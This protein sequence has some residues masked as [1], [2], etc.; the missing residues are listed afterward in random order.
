[1]KSGHL[2]TIKLFLRQRRLHKVF[3]GDQPEMDLLKTVP[4]R[5]IFGKTWQPELKVGGCLKPSP[6]GMLYWNKANGSFFRT[7]FLLYSMQWSR[8]FFHNNVFD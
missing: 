8:R 1:M 2:S 7:C 4:K 3:D 5:G 6:L